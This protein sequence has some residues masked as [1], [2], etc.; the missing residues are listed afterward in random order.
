FRKFGRG[1]NVDFLI[2]QVSSASPLCRKNFVARGVVND[3]SDALTFVLQRHRYT[4][5]WKAVG[6]VGGAIKRIDI[7]A[8]VAT[9]AGQSLLFSENVMLGPMLADTLTTQR[10]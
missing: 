5:H 9:G 10:F 8:I 2:V 3:P 7:P 6:E 4:K 1:G